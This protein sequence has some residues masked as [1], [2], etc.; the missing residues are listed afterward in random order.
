MHKI[1]AVFGTRPEAI[2]MCPVVRELRKRAGVQVLVCLSGQHRQ[3]LDSVMERFGIKADF[4]LGVMREGQT[5]FDLTQSILSNVRSVLESAKPDVVLV[6]GDTATAHAAALAAFYMKIPVGHIEAGLRT[7]DASA[8]Y[9]EEFFR[10]AIS[11]MA[12]F[13]FAPTAAAAEN[14]IREGIDNESVFVTGN[15]IIDALLSNVNEDF[16]HGILDW[17]QDSRLVILTAHRRESVGEPLG[18]ML[19]AV[20]RVLDENSGVKVV[21]PVH[22]NPEIRRI[23]TQLLSDCEQ[24]LLTEPLDVFDFHNILSRSFAVLTDSGGIQEEASFLGKP[25]LVMRA[26]TERPEGVSGGVLKLV[27][28]R[29]DDIYR[30][31]RQLIADAQFYKKMSVPSEAFGNGGASVKIADI[32]LKK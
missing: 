23:A 29:E 19:R 8:P 4:D 10:R 30:C 22:L 6:H 18:N 20:R 5:L 2:K 21:Y 15:T 13:H 31:F 14:L 11:V 26:A 17:A 9:P 3:M 24:A 12:K 25:T 1:L 7:Y 27:G 28:T 32:L 16:R